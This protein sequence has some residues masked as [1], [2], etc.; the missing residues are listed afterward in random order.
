MFY[1]SLPT[2]IVRIIHRFYFPWVMQE[3]KEK[4]PEDNQFIVRSCRIDGP[5][6]EFDT[7]TFI[8]YLTAS[9]T[10]RYYRSGCLAQA[11]DLTKAHASDSENIFPRR[12]GYISRAV[13]RMADRRNA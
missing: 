5:L 1:T 2:D 13:R 4:Q 9:Q 10:S 7:S 6:T 11:M 12:G 8:F 3:L